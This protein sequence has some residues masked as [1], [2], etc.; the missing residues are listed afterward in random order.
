[1][2]ELLRTKID[3]FRHELGRT[4]IDRTAR[5]LHIAEL[6]LK[7]ARVVPAIALGHERLYELTTAPKRF[8]GL[9]DLSVRVAGLA[10]LDALAAVAG[11]SP[12]RVRERLA[13]GDLAYVGELDGRMLAHSWFHRGPEPFCEDMP[14]FPSW[15]IPADTFWSYHAFTLPE[16]RASGVFVKVFQVALHELLTTH[17][18]ARVRCLVKASNAPS[19]QL[20]ERMGFHRLGTIVALLVAGARL[21]SWHNADGA[22]HWVQRRGD[23]TILPL[24]PGADGV[25]PPPRTPPEGDPP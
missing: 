24:P 16:A 13:R 22:Q 12:V 1:V 23:T 18:A 9:R 4:D 25:P 3:R 15:G 14:L 6:S 10:D 5:A 8:R 7:A 2:R 21:V 19:V 17:G 11:T 20:H